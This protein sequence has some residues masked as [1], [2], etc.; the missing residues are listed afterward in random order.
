MRALIRQAV[1]MAAGAVITAVILAG[2]GVFAQSEPVPAGAPPAVEGVLAANQYLH[3]QGQVFNPAGGAPL[4]NQSIALRFSLYADANGSSLLWQ[5]N[6]TVVT[7]QDGLFN[8]VIG[9]ANTLNFAIFDGRDLFLGVAVNGEEGR[10]LL[11]VVYVPYA[12][13]ARN[14]DKLDGLGSGDFLRTVAYGIVDENGNRVR[15]EGFGSDV[16]GDNVYEISISG[17]SYH[18]NDFVTVVTPITQGGCPK[19]TIAGTNSKDGK[20]L[21]ELFDRDGSRVRCKFHFIVSRP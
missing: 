20:L 2:S 4:A 13:F 7:N 14:A 18:L 3:Y 6:Q 15:G 17:E 21:V 1:A 5:E 19:P 9:K 12:I 16:E 10:P 11:P 8:A